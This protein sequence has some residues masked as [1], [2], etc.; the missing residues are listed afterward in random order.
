M[1]YNISDLVGLSKGEISEVVYHNPTGTAEML[2]DLIT[3]DEG[4]MFDAIDTLIDRR[5]DNK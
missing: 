4:D 1:P 3:A 5:T 2:G